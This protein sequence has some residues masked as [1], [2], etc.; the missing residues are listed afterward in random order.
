MSNSPYSLLSLFKLH[1]TWLDNL[2]VI[3]YQITDK[4]PYY[5]LCLFLICRVHREDT[6]NSGGK[7]VICHD[8]TELCA[9]HIRTS[10]SPIGG[11][12][13]I[14]A[15]PIHKPFPLCWLVLFSVFISLVVYL[16]SLFTRSRSFPFISFF[17]CSKYKLC[18]KFAFQACVPK[19][20]IT[21]SK[22]LLTDYV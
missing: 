13:W 16:L 21:Q 8:V 4:R 19:P 1:Y 10:L 6:S 12:V 17:T 20:N 2:Y 3:T 18:H 7:Y 14:A 15:L 5:F 11:K 22:V 9:T